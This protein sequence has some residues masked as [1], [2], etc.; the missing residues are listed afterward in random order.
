MSM[1]K[2]S[3]IIILL[4]LGNAILFSQVLDPKWL[5]VIKTTDQK[6]YLDT[7]NIK[8]VDGQV[9]VVSL[10]QFD[11]PQYV[12]A[13]K[14]EAQSIKSQV[15]F[16]LVSKKYTVLGSLFYDSQLKIIGESSLPGFSLGNESFAI[17][18]DSNMVM[19][20]LYQ[21]AISILNIDTTNY[22]NKEAMSKEEKL[23]S[24]IDNTITQPVDS[25]NIKVNEPEKIVD[26]KLS[27]ANNG[28]KENPKTSKQKSEKTVGNSETSGGQVYNLNAER[29]I[30]G[31][32]FTDGNKYCLQL[33]SWKI[34]SRA[35]KEVARLKSKG[36]NAFIVEANIPSKGGTW[37]R[38]RV[39]YFNSLEETENY[40][41]RR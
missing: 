13:Y 8:R 40:L 11:K 20:A 36:E 10:T 1:R 41:K 18:I 37:Y 9:T 21:K 2:A 25:Q 30:K 38:V 23:R 17:T 24:L 19:K 39:G 28:V 29:N 12:S 14:K 32:I 34:K 33:S 4:F 35:D 31:T 6:V 27:E 7:T 22:Y 26:K 3:L 5:Q 16:N 15:L